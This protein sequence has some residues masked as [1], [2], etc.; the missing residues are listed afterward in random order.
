MVYNFDGNR[1][2]LDFWGDITIVSSGG[3]VVELLLAV[4]D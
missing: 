1:E 2:E 4:G 3:E